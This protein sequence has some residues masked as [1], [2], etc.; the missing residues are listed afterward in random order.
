MSEQTKEQTNPDNE[1]GDQ[2]Y[3]NRPVQGRQKK[4]VSKYGFTLKSSTKPQ[5]LTKSNTAKA[6]V[7]K[8]AS[9]TVES[10]LRFF[11]TV[12]RS[13]S[14]VPANTRT[15]RSPSPT[16]STTSSVNT[17]EY[18]VSP[19]RSAPT[20]AYMSAEEEYDDKDEKSIVKIMKSKM[21]QFSNEVD[22]EMSIFELGLVLDR[23]WPHG[24]KL[25][26]VEYMTSPNYQRSLT[27]DM[28]TRADR[29]IYFALTTASK[30][31]SFAKLQIMA[32]CHRDAIP[33]VLKN[34]G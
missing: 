31:D 34:E 23:V 24:D 32:S 15:R 5:I 29:L 20:V 10:P 22:W 18:T 6:E 12:Q 26:I 11:K 7:T 17:V 30:K 21:P 16:K 19:N 8:T 28:E 4:L 14:P 9:T 33:C 3:W 27:E 25:D 13:T 2:T 1:F